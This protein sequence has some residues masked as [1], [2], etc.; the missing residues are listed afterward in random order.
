MEKIS[1]AALESSGLEDSSR[2]IP[3]AWKRD[4]EGFD[5]SLQ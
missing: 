4:G 1:A 5:F 2:E 3:A